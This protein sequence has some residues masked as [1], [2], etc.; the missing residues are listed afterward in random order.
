MCVVNTHHPL[1][2]ALQHQVI[3]FVVAQKQNASRDSTSL[4]SLLTTPFYFYL[5]KLF[6]LVAL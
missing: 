2:V 1:F 5:W 6:H 4:F 3:I